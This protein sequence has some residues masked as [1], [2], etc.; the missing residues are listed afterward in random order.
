MIIASAILWEDKIYTGKR[1]CNIISDMVTKHG[2]KPP[3]KGKQ[4]FIDENGNFLDR[5]TA[6]KIAIE[7]KQIEKLN[8]PPLLYSEDL[9]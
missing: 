1:H 5:K 6:A 8:W 3:I 9:W 2:I 4:G 7:T